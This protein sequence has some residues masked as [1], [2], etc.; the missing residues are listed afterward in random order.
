MEGMVHNGGYG[1]MK[2]GHNGGY[3]PVK[4]MRHGWFRMVEWAPWCSGLQITTLFITTRI[5]LTSL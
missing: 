2:G 1:A 4:T 5:E 3:L